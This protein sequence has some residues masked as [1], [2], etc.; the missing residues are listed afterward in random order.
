MGKVRNTEQHFDC[1][2]RRLCR[3]LNN[4]KKKKK[5]KKKNIIINQDLSMTFENTNQRLNIW[6]VIPHRFLYVCLSVHLAVFL[7]LSICLCLSDCLSACHCGVCMNPSTFSTL[8]RLR[9]VNA[10]SFERLWILLANVGLYIE[11]A[12]KLMPIQSDGNNLTGFFRVPG[13]LVQVQIPIPGWWCCRVK[14]TYSGR[15][16][17]SRY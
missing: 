3:L 9:G 12:F 1:I 16:G 7:F 5:K 4:N 2:W 17:L 13:S 6:E 10:N 15:N 14:C 8:L 11:S